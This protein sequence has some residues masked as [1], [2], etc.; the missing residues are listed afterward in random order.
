MQSN[1]SSFQLNPYILDEDLQTAR[2]AAN[3]AHD[4]DDNYNDDDSSMTYLSAEMARLAA[5]PEEALPWSDARQDP[6][7]LR[8]EQR[9]GF[10]MAPVAVVFS[11]IS[12]LRN[13]RTVLEDDLVASRI[14]VGGGADVRV[15]SLIHI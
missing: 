13:Q 12:A 3:A 6:Q 10:S 2:K 14:K 11:H 15:L 9:T 5:L 1:V 8:L 4:D 7:L